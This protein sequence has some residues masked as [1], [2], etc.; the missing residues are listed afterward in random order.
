MDVV[1]EIRIKHR[2]DVINAETEAREAAK[3]EG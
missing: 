1:Q 2:W 3:L